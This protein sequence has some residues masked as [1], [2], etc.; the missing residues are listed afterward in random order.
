MRWPHAADS[1]Y[2]WMAAVAEGVDGPAGRITDRVVYAA[3]PE[4]QNLA[5]VRSED[6]AELV[7][8]AGLTLSPD[9][10]WVAFRTQS[11]SVVDNEHRA[12]WYVT[13][14]G[15]GGP[16]AHIGSAGR[17]VIED[18]FLEGALHN[19]GLNPIAAWSPDSGRVAFQARIA[20]GFALYQGGVD[21]A[22]IRLCE[23]DG[24]VRAL[25]YHSRG[26]PLLVRTCPPRPTPVRALLDPDS[27]GILVGPD[28][29][30]HAGITALGPH[31]EQGDPTD[32][33][34][35]PAT[36]ARRRATAAE[37]ALLDEDPAA[38]PA[39]LDLPGDPLAARLCPNGTR[40]AYI[41]YCDDPD[42]PNLYVASR[43][44]PTARRL[45]TTMPA[46]AAAWT[47]Q[48]PILWWS[49][50]GTAL[51]FQARGRDRDLG[52]YRVAL[53]GGRP[54]RISP[55][56]EH[57][58][59]RVDPLQGVA[60]G[61]AASLT[62][63]PEVV[64]TDLHTGRTRRLTDA[65][66]RWQRLRSGRI[67]RI[68][69]DNDYGDR[70]WAHLVEPP[71]HRAGQRLPMVVTTYASRGF[72]RG[73]SGDEYPIR[74]LADHGFLVLD[75]EHPRGYE[76]EDPDAGH[77]PAERFEAMYKDMAGPLSSLR[78]MIEVLD[79]DG[80]VDRD[81]IGICGFSHGSDIATYAL[82]YSS[83][84]RAAVLSGFSHDDDY[85]YHLYGP[86]FDERWRDWGLGG[87]PDGPHS[88]HWQRRSPGAQRI[89]AAVL[90]HDTHGEYLAGVSAYTR[91]VRA[92]A[93]VEMHVYPRED[94]VKIEPRHRL[95]VY[96][97]TVDWFDF[98]LRDVEDV[99]P[100]KSEQ[101]RRWRELRSAV[102]HRS[103]VAGAGEP[104]GHDHGA[105]DPR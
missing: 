32:W 62:R 69:V 51:Y 43:H 11:G 83:L 98:W 20:A 25:R 105:V 76:I 22:P 3:P 53:H 54:C 31:A 41:D 15:A 52:L 38:P 89:T 99:D 72:L 27:D 44:D 61:L 14:T 29:R 82:Q 56:G 80:V 10:A 47:E 65:N 2:G 28:A 93:P 103:P 24:V 4:A 91:M 101:Y 85:T 68:E 87:G 45:V 74:V 12:E 7:D 23:L 67:R 9:A 97:R 90:N 95:D 96:R 21:V 94:H 55:G 19:G 18:G 58:E 73:A 35:D 71:G 13:R 77:S 50:D 37:T 104:T 40:V 48:T 1:L 88:A 59:H 5:P 42:R 34:V 26:N 16:T 39:H 60:V 46:S 84:F 63:P 6:L 102:I 79:A 64:A 86:G 81:R 70:T 92:G 78:T 66:P 57:A 49:G 8:I 36:G 75:L 100:E 30:F 33:A 17:A